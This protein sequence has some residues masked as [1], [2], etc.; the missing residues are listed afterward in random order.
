VKYAAEV[1]SNTVASEIEEQ[2]WA[3]TGETVRFIRY[4]NKF[5]DVLNGAFSTHHIVTRNQDLAPYKNVLDNRFKWLE[6]DFLKYLEEWEAQVRAD[7]KRLGLSALEQDERLLSRQS[8]QGLEIS[9]RGFIGVTKLLLKE[10][11]SYVN[12]RTF[13]QDVLEQHFSLH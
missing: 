3:S 4:F 5:F 9:V 2:G 7:G 10:G 13:S 12:A 1:L 6:D 8:R 11:A